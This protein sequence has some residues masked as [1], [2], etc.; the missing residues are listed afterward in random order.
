M[1]SNAIFFFKKNEKKYF[2]HKKSDVATTNEG[3]NKTINKE[4][5]KLLFLILTSLQNWLLT[6]K[7]NCFVYVIW[8]YDYSLLHDLEKTF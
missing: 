8:N 4:V 7:R 1:H 5:F 6:L 2:Q 3:S